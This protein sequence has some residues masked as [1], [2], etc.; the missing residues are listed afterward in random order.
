[1]N[2]PNA[3]GVFGKNTNTSGGLGVS[4][5]STDGAG[6]RGEDYGNGVGV[7]GLSG[8]DGVGVTGVD[9]DTGGVG[10]VGEG[11]V[12]GV[13]GYSNTAGAYGVYGSTSSQ[14][15]YGVYGY[16][17]NSSGTAI[18]AKAT[19]G[20]GLEASATAGYGVYGTVTTG[21]GVVAAA[22]GT[23][24]A[25]LQAT[26]DGSDGYAIIGI[27][28]GQCSGSSCYAGYFEG[29]VDVLG[30]FQV[31][32]TNEFGCSSDRR[33]KQNIEPLAGALD[34]I[35]KLKGVTFDWRNP[36]HQ[37]KNAYERQTGFVAQDVEEY[38]PGW[39]DEGGD[40]FKTL[41]I[42]PNHIDALEVEAIRDLKVGNDKLKAE[43][44]DLRQ[45]V[46]SLESG[47]RV[48]AGMNVNGIG[49]A[50]GGLV[51]AGALVYTRRRRE[52]VA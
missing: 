49:F 3:A 38:F 36:E 26:A 23:G 1:V 51:I 50:F 22:S 46:E 24:G 41:T 47:R 37:G 5:S 14:T 7:S 21:I 35:L 4:G 18:Y 39:V 25:G 16:N 6:V 28:G 10:V 29:N 31:N 40:G 30:C 48:I 12:Y 19:S 2:D 43:N 8:A 13:H 9:V 15:G 42:P 33:L 27:T 44:E 34:T 20:A 45:R 52:V 32:G 17:S 11:T